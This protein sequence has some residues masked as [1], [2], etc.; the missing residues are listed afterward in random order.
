MFVN[1]LTINSLHKKIAVFS[2]YIGTTVS[3]FQNEMLQVFKN[4]NMLLLKFVGK[5]DILRGSAHF[6]VPEHLWGRRGGQQAT[7]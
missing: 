3:S 1:Y 6:T 4:I 2:Y 7:S 5:Q